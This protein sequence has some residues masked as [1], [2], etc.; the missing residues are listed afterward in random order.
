MRPTG[1]MHSTMKWKKWQCRILGGAG[2]G[3]FVCVTICYEINNNRKEFVM[4][5]AYRYTHAI[6]CRLSDSF[7]KNA[8]GTTGVINMP[9][10]RQQHAMYVSTLRL[11]GL[12]VIELPPDEALP[13]CVFVEDT[14]IVVNGTALITRP[15][16]PNRQKEVSFQLRKHTFTRCCF[17]CVW[18]RGYW[19]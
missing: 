10:A 5:L 15:G 19:S 17:R 3:H 4:A 6:V 1:E 12:D 2:D 13:D 9:L 7:E 11:L 18:T 8:V 14:A 16:H